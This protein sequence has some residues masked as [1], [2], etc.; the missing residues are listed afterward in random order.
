M[1][2]KIGDRVLASVNGTGGLFS[3]TVTGWMEVARGGRQYAVRFDGDER[4]SLPCAVFSRLEPLS[5]LRV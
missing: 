5:A 2:A 3:G 4:H 1:E